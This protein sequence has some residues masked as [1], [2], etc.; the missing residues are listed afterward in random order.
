MN[1]SARKRATQAEKKARVDLVIQAL[2]RDIAEDHIITLLKKQGLSYRQARRYVNLALE[3]LYREAA[4]TDPVMVGLIL[5]QAK[6]LSQVAYNQAVDQQNNP[7][8]KAL[9][10]GLAAQKGFAV[11]QKLLKASPKK[12][13][14]QEP[15]SNDSSSGSA[16]LQNL[17]QQLA[18][19]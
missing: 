9:R 11:M 2:M 12:D 15:I 17:L 13:A 18:S 8:G 5:K 1:S 7:D 19:A 4:E 6:H 10:N 3:E 16:V 14:R